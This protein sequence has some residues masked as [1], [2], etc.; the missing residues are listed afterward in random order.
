MPSRVDVLAVGGLVADEQIRVVSDVPMCTTPARCRRHAGRPGLT[1]LTFRVPF[2]ADQD[3]AI[4]VV[5]LGAASEAYT[6]EIEVIGPLACEDDGLEDNDQITSGTP[7]AVGST[8]GGCC[9]AT[10]PTSS[11]WGPG[12]HHHS[13]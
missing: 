2:A 8:L 3:Y 1:D 5:G 10:T 12:W 4:E 6:L 7:V 13:G 9:A 11:R